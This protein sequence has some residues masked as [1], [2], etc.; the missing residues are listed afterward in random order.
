VLVE[1][2][3]DGTAVMTD[4]TLIPRSEIYAVVASGPRGDPSRRV[5][6]QAHP[7]RIES[8]VYRVGGLL[9]APPGVDPAERFAGGDHMVPLT[10]AWLEYPWG[11]RRRWDERATVI[12]NRRADTTLEVL[13]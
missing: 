1:E 4:E 11:E 9:H 10:E 5:E 13:G 6:T 8:G 2:S 7:V 3:R 12:V